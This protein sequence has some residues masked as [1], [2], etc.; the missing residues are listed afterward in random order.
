MDRSI[1]P[2]GEFVTL[3]GVF[4]VRE[5]GSERYMRPDHAGVLSDKMPL[6]GFP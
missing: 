6:K 2:L 3:C 5:E 4:A 1:K